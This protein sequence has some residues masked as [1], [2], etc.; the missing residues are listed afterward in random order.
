VRRP[1]GGNSG[2]GFRG[3]RTSDDV[4]QAVVVEVVDD[5]AAGEI[6]DVEMEPAGDVGEALDLRLW[7]E[8]AGGI[9]HAF[10]TLLDIAQGHGSE[11]H[12][13][14]RPQVIAELSSCS[15]KILIASPTPARGCGRRSADRQTHDSVVWRARQFSCSPR[16]R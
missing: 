16:R 14:A 3:A 13:P 7:L 11:V 9:S 8:A 10:G 5:D 1:G 6:V 2:A 15:V 4:E 12:E